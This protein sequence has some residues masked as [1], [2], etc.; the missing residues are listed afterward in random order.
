[1]KTVYLVTGSEDGVTG[2][3]SSKAKAF[4]SAKAYCKIETDDQYNEML[5][6]MDERRQS[7]NI[8]FTPCTGIWFFEEANFG[9]T[10][11]VSKE[12]VE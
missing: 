11:T 1:M 9:V 7:L 4:V 6:E 3:F 10:A 2:I 5:N 8:E 12:Y